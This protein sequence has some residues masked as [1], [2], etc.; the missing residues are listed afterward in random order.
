MN[1]AMLDSKSS[2]DNISKIIRTIDEIA[3]QTN[4]L[5]LNAAVEAARAG[6]AGLGFAV[7]AD[8]VRN[9]ASRSAQAAKETAEKIEQSIAKSMAGVEYTN[10][11]TT[12]LTGITDKVRQVDDIFSEIAEAS[13]E[14]SNGISEINRAI[15]QMSTVT[16]NNAAAAEESASAS[17]E[18]RAQASSLQD[19][20][21][22]LEHLVKGS[23]AAS[24]P[25]EE[26]RFE[27]GSPSPGSSRPSQPA[28]REV[29]DS[30]ALFRAERLSLRGGSQEGDQDFVDI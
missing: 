2:S 23:K 25:K 21:A 27:G 13:K 12:G 4:I 10:K 16:Q 5:A 8:E 18:L 9:L 14:Q 24:A 22:G 11:V 28:Q 20:I 26:I 15:G 7:V 1:R 29:K 17:E 19:F 6:E 30:H 3:F